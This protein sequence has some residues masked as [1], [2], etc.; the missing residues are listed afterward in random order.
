MS[1]FRKKNKQVHKGCQLSKAAISSIISHEMHI[2]GDIRF[3]G[4]VR[5]DGTVKGNIQGE[6]LI[7]GENGKITG[8]LKLDV[9]I[10]HGTVDGN[11][12]SRQVNAHST[13]S[14]RGIVKSENL[15][16]EP[17]AAID[18]EIK[19][20]SEQGNKTKEGKGREKSIPAKAEK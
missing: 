11:I 3:N 19:A 14:I 6:Y 18:G 1:F 15:T 20:F 12:D 9:L 10:C 16:V 17:S 7:I 13:A 5:I 8:D 2:S 4:K